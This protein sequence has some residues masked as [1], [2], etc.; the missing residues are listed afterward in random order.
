MLESQE[1]AGLIPNIFLTLAHRP[2]K[3]RAF[4]ACRNECPDRATFGLF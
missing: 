2:E 1:K 4:L 3:F